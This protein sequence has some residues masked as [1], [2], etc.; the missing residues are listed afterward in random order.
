LVAP[1]IILA[2]ATPG[3]AATSTTLPINVGSVDA[4]STANSTLTF[5]V[6]AGASG[7]VVSLKVSG[8]FTG[9]K[10]SDSFKVTLP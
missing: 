5:P 1:N 10:F 4:G 2:K 9:G 7:A 8:A 3:A 6:S